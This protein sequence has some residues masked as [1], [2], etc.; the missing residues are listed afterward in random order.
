MDLSTDKNSFNGD[1]SV[2]DFGRRIEQRQLKSIL[3]HSSDPT[4]KAALQQDEFT[5]NKPT[6]NDS[7]RFTPNVGHH[8]TPYGE[9]PLK[10]EDASLGD[11]ES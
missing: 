10:T 3:L 2:Y 6:T 9:T 1:A 4:E 11:I 5:S 7:L 8:V